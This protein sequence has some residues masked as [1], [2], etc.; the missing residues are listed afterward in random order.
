MSTTHP[1][2]ALADGFSGQLIGPEQPG[3]DEGRRVFNAMIDRRPALIARC[4]STPDVVAAVHAAREHGQV[5]VR[6]GGH[7]FSGLVHLRRRH[8]DRP[9]RAEVDRGRPAGTDRAGRGRRALGRV[10]R[11]HSGARAAHPGRP[12]HHHR[13]RWLHHR[14]RIRLDVVQA[15]PGLRQPHFRRGGPGRREGGA[16]QRAGARR[17]VLGHPRRQRQLRHRY[18]VRVPPA[19]ARPDR[20][21]RADGVPRRSCAGG[22]ALLARL[23]RRRARRGVHRLRRDHRAARA[24]RPGA[25]AR[26]AGARHTRALRGRPGGRGGGGAAAQGAR[27]PPWTTSARCP[28]PPSRRSWTRSRRP[29]GAATRAESTCPGSATPRSTPSSPTPPA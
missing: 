15:R 6:G 10:R 16:R 7:S 19:S 24:V 14:W 29:D 9:R 2:A 21:R 23:G 13:A 3:Y 22:P 27:R 5:A 12:R 4:A 17:P 1:A 25:P 8:S 11:R 20:A 26:P 28:T 18:R